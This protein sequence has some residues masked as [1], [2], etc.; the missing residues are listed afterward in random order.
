MNIWSKSQI[1]MIALLGLAII[2]LLL[3][4]NQYQ[5]QTLDAY[6][7]DERRE[8][9]ITRQNLLPQDMIELYVGGWI[10]R[11]KV[12]ISGLPSRENEALVFSRGTSV[13]TI[14]HAYIG[15]WY[16]PDIHI[17]FQPSEEAS[18]LVRVIYKYK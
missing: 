11:G 4:L 15:E 8:Y 7:C 12:A 1:V 14:S 9:V 2:L 6:R 17:I 18:C 5:Y 16:E 3:A 10:E 13:G